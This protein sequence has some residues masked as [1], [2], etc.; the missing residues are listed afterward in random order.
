TLADEIDISRGDLIT[1][2]NDLP[3]VAQHLD[4]MICW[5]TEKKMRPRGRFA[6]RHTTREVKAVVQ[7]VL[8]KVDITTLEKTQESQEFS[9]NEIGCIRLRLSQ[10]IFFDSYA[11]N[12]VT[13]SFVLVDEQT[14]N[15]VAAGMILRAVGD[16][17]T[18]D[19]EAYAI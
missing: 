15:T 18:E 7:S 17:T 2:A 10:P 11:D 13:G 14:N 3:H 4:A 16:A 19:P 1:S 8:Y 12:R 9:M 5:F 6:L